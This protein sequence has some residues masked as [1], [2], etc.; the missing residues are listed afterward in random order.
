MVTYLSNTYIPKLELDLTKSNTLSFEIKCNELDTII[1]A[2]RKVVYHNST[3]L[4]NL[5][6][7]LNGY[8][9]K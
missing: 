9:K 8:Q 7:D 2:Q 1:K 3:A 5:R 4:G 6:K